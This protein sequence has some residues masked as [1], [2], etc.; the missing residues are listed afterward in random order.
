MKRV[1]LVGGAF[2]LLTTLALAQPAIQALTGNEAVLAQAGGPGGSG[3]FTTVAALR[4]S[5]G[6]TAVATGGTVNQ[7]VPN[8]TSQI[9]VTG[10]ITTL[11]LT[12]PTAPYDGQTVQI[13][14]PGGAATTVAVTYTPGTLVGTAFTTCASGG[15]SPAGAEWIYSAS[16]TTWYRIQ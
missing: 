6:Y 5:K 2:G 4:G 3:F 13:A 10:A 11:N 1:L 16:N 15:V 12:M 9:V 8:T 14:C 7:T